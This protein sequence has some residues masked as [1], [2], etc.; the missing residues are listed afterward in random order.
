V[1][2]GGQ[3]PGRRSKP[4]RRGEPIYVRWQNHLPDEHLL[5]ED[6]TIHG[7]IIPYDERAPASF[8]TSTV[9]T[10]NTRATGNR[11]RGS[12]VTSKQTGP[13]FEKKDYYYAN[14]QPPATLWYHDHSLGITR[15]NVY[16]GL[17]GFYLLRNDHER[18]LDLP[19]SDNEIPLVLQDRSFNEDGSLYYPTDV[20]ATEEDENDSHPDPSIVP[21]F[22]GGTSTVN[23]RHGPDCPSIP[24]STGSACSTVP[25]ADTTTSSCSNTTR[26]RATRVRHGAAVRPDRERR[27]APSRNRS[28]PLTASNSDRVSARTSSSTSVSTRAR[29]LL[30]HN[31]APAKYRGTSGIG[32]DDSEPL[33]EVMLIDVAAAES[34]QEPTQPQTNWTQVP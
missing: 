2:Y 27:R 25:T 23:G 17:A 6:P 30:L 10:S 16:A 22:Y 20:P 1:G 4:N 33:P 26:N 11:R 32:P 15:L 31:N 7:D 28:R 24:N 3:F 9:A 29:P 14:E 8:R 13:D 12:P 19:T 21:Q 18:E 34:E 5:P